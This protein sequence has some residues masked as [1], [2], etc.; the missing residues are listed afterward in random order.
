MIYVANYAS[1]RYVESQRLQNHYWA[2]LPSPPQ[3]RSF[4]KED[5]LPILRELRLPNESEVRA[6]LDEKRGDGLWAWKAILTYY[7]YRDIAA[8]GDIVFFMDSGACPVEPFDDVWR[9][10]ETLGSLFVRVSAFET[11]PAVQRWLGGVREMAPK[12]ALLAN[13]DFSSRLWTRPFPPSPGDPHGL[14]PCVADRL[15]GLPGAFHDRGARLL[16]MEQVCGGFQGYLKRDGNDRILKD[17]LATTTLQYF[18]DALRGADPL[19]YI[20]HRH[21]QSMLSLIV[22]AECLRTP[23]FAE[24]VVREFRPV[25]LHRGYD[26]NLPLGARDLM[27]AWA[28]H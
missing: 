26:E 20:D 15:Q 2:T 5:V 21:D 23:A 19:S 18:D 10:I 16:A 8:E 3:V 24:C 7:V 9:H 13:V 11:A 25:C 6:V 4:R 12:A 28:G 22:N 1:N 17:L 14:P 27:A